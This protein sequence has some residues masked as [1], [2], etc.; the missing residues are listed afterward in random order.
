[1]MGC[2]RR[3]RFQPAIGSCLSLIAII[4]CTGIQGPAGPVLTGNLT[5]FV[6]LHDEYGNDLS[7][8]AG[9]L[10]QVSGTN[11]SATTDVDGKWTIWGLTTGTYDLIFSKQGFGTHTEPSFQFVGG[12][13]KYTYTDYLSQLPSYHVTSI[14]LDSIDSNY[15]H[16][17]A[18][19]SAPGMAGE[20]RDLVFFIGLTPAVDCSTANYLTVDVDSYHDAGLDSVSA[21]LWL[22]SSKLEKQNS[23]T[24]I[25]IVAYGCSHP[26][27]FGYH[28]DVNTGKYVYTCLSSVP[29]N[30]LPVILP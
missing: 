11:H 1:M 16:I 8:H 22:H 24:T 20:Y 6:I 27:Y 19:L 25:Y 14:A 5:G 3:Q 4:G 9:V 13:T 15:I 7:D 12:G 2:Y 23:G 21:D 18:T 29:S 26:Y 28:T 30:T 17:S 10:I